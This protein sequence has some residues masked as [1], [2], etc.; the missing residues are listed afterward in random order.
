MLHR[1]SSGRV[2]MN[3]RLIRDLFD[4]KH[5]ILVDRIGVRDELH[6]GSFRG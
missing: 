4:Y 2:S 5:S 3:G 1:D 6:R